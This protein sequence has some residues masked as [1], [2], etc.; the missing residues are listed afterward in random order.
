MGCAWHTC[1]HPFVHTCTLSSNPSYTA[2]DSPNRLAGDANGVP[3]VEEIFLSLCNFQMKIAPLLHFGRFMD[4]VNVF[5]TALFQ[6]LKESG[7]SSVSKGG[8]QLMT[9]DAEI[10]LLHISMLETISRSRSSSSRSPRFSTTASSASS[11]PTAFL[12][13][14]S[15]T[16]SSL[17]LHIDRDSPPEITQHLI[18][19][20]DSDPLARVYGLNQGGALN[21]SLASLVIFIHPLS[22][23][24]PL[25]S[26]GKT[27][28]G[29]SFYLT[30]LSATLNP[31]ASFPPPSY[32]NIDMSAFSSSP[33]VS[34]FGTCVRR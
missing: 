14:F 32:T 16:A 29:G 22:A 33:P 27:T 19:D 10:S 15:A 28:I 21:I 31:T 17:S 3:L 24:T 25:V 11:A 4:F 23:V 2:D 8:Y 9:I 7:I 6:G 5:K 18:N 13:R 30:P 26:L 1:S 34:R 12:E 20:L